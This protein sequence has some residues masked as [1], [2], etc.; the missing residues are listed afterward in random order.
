[1]TEAGD[2]LLEYLDKNKENDIDMREAMVLFSMD[3]IGSA[4]FGINPGVLKNP[5]SE[6]RVKGKQISEPNWK[7]LVR[8]WKKNDIQRNDFIQMM[9]HLKEKGKI[10]VK[11]L[12]S[13]DD[14]LN[15]ELND[16]NNE[17]FEITDDILL[18]QAQS[19]LLAGFESTALLLAYAMLEICQKPQLQDTL[20]K[21]IVE[22]VKLNGGL[23]YEALRNLKLLEQAVKAIHLDPTFYPDPK[24]FKPERFA[25]QPKPGTFLPFGEGLRMCI[26]MMY[27]MLVVKFGL[28]LFLLNYRA[29]LSPSTSYPVKFNNR[30][31]TLTAIWKYSK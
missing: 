7:N 21:E 3:I 18:A 5:E 4:A 27:A 31:A 12:D 11:T 17:V 2:G 8:I 26:A 28:A 30:A 20:R 25:E 6:F 24:S 29:K 16:T 14:Y 15:T 9:V 10:E 19:F 22:Q 1:M 13:S 23:T